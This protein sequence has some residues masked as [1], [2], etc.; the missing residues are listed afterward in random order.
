M[1]NK[2]LKIKNNV[3]ALYIKNYIFNKNSL[4]LD[5]KEFKKL[6]YSSNILIFDFL[7]IN[8]KFPNNKYYIGIGKLKEL[9]KYI[10]KIKC[11]LL[12]FNIKLKGSQEYNL[13]CFFKCNILDRTG[14]ILNIFKKRT[15][16]Y[17]GK[18]QVE[19]AYLNYLSTRLVRRWRHLERQR[20]G[21]RYIS[22]PGEKQLEIDKRLIKSKI[23]KVNTCLCRIF[24]QRNKSSKLRNKYNIPVVSLVGYTN[25][26][27]STLFNLLT[28]SDVKV[29][30]KYFS[31]LDP[32]IKKIKLLD[33]HKSILLSDTVGFINNLPLDIV[34]AFRST[35]NEINDSK[36]ILH[37]VDISNLYFQRNINIVNKT[38]SFIKVFNSIPVIQIMNKIDKIKYFKEKIELDKNNFPYRIWVSAKYKNG[39]NLI[40][41]VIRKFFYM[42]KIE[43]NICVPVNLTYEIRKF[44]YS[45]NLVKNEYS[46]NGID[47]YFKILL[48]KVDFYNFVNKFP[49]IKKFLIN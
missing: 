30:N 35:L 39:I 4:Y 22:G 34:N 45:N 36:L 28:E 46:I 33:T 29:E 19:L 16:T 31:T 14:L 37:V 21:F 47:F 41:E 15:N 43:Y 44:L 2:K 12:V 49:F 20:G 32:F 48:T 17:L 13:K 8:V 18:L 38:L 25:S 42:I 3:L 5:I 9:S 6:I 7:E 26:G 24:F 23:K 11:S 10:K 1:C 40:L 27:K